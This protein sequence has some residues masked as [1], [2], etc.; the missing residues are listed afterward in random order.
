MHLLQ[1]ARALEE[2]MPQILEREG[3]PLAIDGFA[4]RRLKGSKVK[5]DST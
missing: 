5:S 3:S 1:T 2:G 4:I